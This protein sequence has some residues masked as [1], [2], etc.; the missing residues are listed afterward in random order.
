MASKVPFRQAK[1]LILLIFFDC[2]KRWNAGPRLTALVVASEERILA[3]QSNRADQVLDVVG[4]DLATAVAR[5]G[6]QPFQ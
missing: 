2:D 5:E 4:V 6:L 1:F 3:G